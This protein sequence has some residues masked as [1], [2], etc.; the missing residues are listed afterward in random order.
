[1]SPE[2]ILPAAL[3]RVHSKRQAPWV[4]I[5]GTTAL[6]MVLIASGDLSELTDT[7]VLFLLVVFTAVN[8][9]VLVLRRDPVGHR[10]FRAPTIVPVIGALMSVALRELVDAR[11]PRAICNRGARGRPRRL[12]AVALVS[13]AYGRLE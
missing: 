8:I 12:P 5:I 11:S 9:A 7:T 1:M 3:G 6:A 10:H 2:R 13:G 4:A